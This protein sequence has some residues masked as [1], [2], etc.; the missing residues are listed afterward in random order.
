MVA[1]LYTPTNNG[2]ESQLLHILINACISCL[3]FSVA[4]DGLLQIWLICAILFVVLIFFAFPI[5]TRFRSVFVVSFVKLSMHVVSDK[6]D[7]AVQL[8]VSFL[9]SGSFY[10]CFPKIYPHPQ[11]PSVPSLL[12]FFFFLLH[13]FCLVSDAL[14]ALICILVFVDS[15]SLLVLLKKNLQSFFFPFCF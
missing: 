2:W 5:Q 12:S 14:H 4:A 15:V 10:W 1:L 11:P 13:S 3:I 7:I 8:G 9:L 6:R